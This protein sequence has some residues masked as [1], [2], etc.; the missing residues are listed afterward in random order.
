MVGE[1]REVVTSRLRLWLP[2]AAGAGRMLGF[3]LDEAEHLRRWSPPTPPGWATVPYWERRLAAD[4]E[5]AE[6][7]RTLRLAISW[8]DD[9]ERRV[10]GTIALT[11]LVRG[12]LQQA[13]LGYALAARAQ[14]KGIMVEAV[15]AVAA[16]A[17]DD[18][19]LHRLAANYM[20]T[21]ERSARVLRRAGF[22]VVGY[23]RDYLFID[24]AW[25]DHVLTALTV[26]ARARRCEPASRPPI[27]A[28]RSRPSA[29]PPRRR[30]ARA[31]RGW[32]GRAW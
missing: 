32:R 14:G 11:E 15:T 22:V 2:G 6:A 28:P 3:H 26:P 8:R 12:A 10:L 5:D 9:D 23:A 16:H 7:G 4:V 29:P 21:N 19:R 13:N 18:M 27:R 25:R 31:S 20:P 1:P 30:A 24:G 17:F